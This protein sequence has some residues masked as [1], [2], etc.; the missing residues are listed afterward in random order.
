MTT[1]LSSEPVVLAGNHRTVLTLII[2]AAQAFGSRIAVDDG[3]KSYTFHDL[4][5]IA[6]RGGSTLRAYGVESGDRVIVSAA[7]AVEVLEIFLA[8]AWIGAVFVPLNPELPSAQ[9]P[10]LQEYLR[11]R[12]A[13]VDRTSEQTS[14]GAWSREGITTLTIGAGSSDTHVWRLG[15]ES[16]DLQPAGPGVPLA[17]L[18]TSGTTGRSKGVVCPHGQFVQWGE[19]VGAQLQLCPGDVAYTCL[20]LFHTNALNAFMQTITYGATYRL[21]ERFSVSR[22][23]ERLRES[24]A[25]VTYLLGAMVGMLLSRDPSPSDRDHLV[26]RILAP[27]TPS[28][29]VTAFEERFGARLL[30]GHGMTETNL[31]LAPPLGERKLGYMGTVL[32]GF[33]AR[34]VDVDGHDVPPGIAGELLL[35]CHIPWAFALGYWELP[36]AT[37][38]SRV[39][40]WF[41]TGDRVIEEDGWYRF[42]DRLKDV[43]RRRGE[44]ISA[45]EVEQALESSPLVA[46]SAVVPV[47]SELGEDEVMAFIRLEPGN[48]AEPAAIVEAVA[49]RLPRFA[50]PRYVEFVTQFPLTDTGK[51]RK[52]V[53]RERGVS[54]TTW[55]RTPGGRPAS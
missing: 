39:G 29:A 27:G 47:P 43:I 37:A 2:S 48:T 52:Q 32:P 10:E 14:P 54:D 1:G 38:A 3:V 33:E 18:M 36:E 55:D 12:L 7:N 23:M 49:D 6:E 5:L 46:Q 30:E 13:L 24:G 34:V 17:I 28:W 21:G 16:A 11:P 15:D 50:V 4:P 8:C 53:L 25:T 44:N 40:D 31:V 41:R 35:R 20:P 9:V 51:I 45:F 19:S 42:V 22:F 26:T